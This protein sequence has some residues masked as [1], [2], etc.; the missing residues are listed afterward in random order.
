MHLNRTWRDGCTRAQRRRASS[1]QLLRQ[2]VIAC[3]SLLALLPCGHALAR[4]VEERQIWATVSLTKKLDSRWAIGADLQ[5]RA[6]DGSDSYVTHY[7]QGRATYFVNPVTPITLGYINLRFKGSG[8]R[9]FN[10]NRF[11]ARIDTEVVRIDDIRI[12]GRV[13]L[14]HRHLDIGRDI[15]WRLRGRATL[16]VP[17]IRKNDE[18]R[19]T[20]Q[21]YF[22]PMVNLRNTDWGA[23]QG[24]DQM[25]FYGGV[26]APVTSSMKIQAGYMLH[27]RGVEDGIRMINHIGVISTEVSF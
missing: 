12:L 20:G 13:Q 4:T 22:E 16:L 18:E 19:L 10:E 2:F 17:L 14:D 27:R 26:S 3:I 21:L 15:S 8:G 24:V 11:Y 1:A 25:R 7:V 5:A 6:R 9:H 23:Q